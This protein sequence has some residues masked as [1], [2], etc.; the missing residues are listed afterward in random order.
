M[1]FD[2]TLLGL[3]LESALELPGQPM[4]ASHPLCYMRERGAMKL[5]F[6][7][8]KTRSKSDGCPSDNYSLVSCVC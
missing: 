8:T 6:G 7:R 3:T 5:V 1:S 4:E 2:M